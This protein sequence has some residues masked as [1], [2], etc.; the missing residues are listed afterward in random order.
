MNEVFE[1]FLYAALEEAFRRIGGSLRRHAP[2]HLDV[3]EGLRMEPDMTWWRPVGRCRAVIDAKYKSLV[4]RAT[5]PNADAY[6]M[7]AYCVALGLPRGFLI[8]AKDDGERTRL[9]RI[10]RHGYEIDVRAVDVELA[11]DRLLRQV[12][13]IAELIAEPLAAAA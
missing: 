7:L 8:Y 4:E 6:Q 1:S 3:E 2:T 10:R 9:H 11:P 12:R 5:M 13:E